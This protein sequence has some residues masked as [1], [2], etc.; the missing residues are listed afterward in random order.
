MVISSMSREQMDLEKNSS[1]CMFNQV[2]NGLLPAIPDMVCLQKQVSS[3]PGTPYATTDCA[4]AGFLRAESL[5][6][7]CFT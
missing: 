6:A 7:V 1:Y 2:L 3:A 5:E 4:N